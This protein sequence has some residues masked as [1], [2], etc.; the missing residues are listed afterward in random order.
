LP[1][2][3]IATVVA[4]V[5]AHNEEQ[6]IAAVISGARR[7]VPVVVVDDGSTD[8]T[9]RI[10]EY[11]SATV[12][13]Q[14]PNQGKGAALRTGF[15]W[16]LAQ[17]HAAVVT[18][19]ADGQHDPSEIPRFLDAWRSGSPDLVIGKR[20]FRTMP[21]VRRL[22]NVLGTAA[23]SWAVGQPIPD[24][25]SGFRLLSARLMEATLSSSEAG[26]EFEVEMIVTAMR[27]GWPIAWVPIRTIYAGEPSHI[28]PGRHLRRF[29]ET[30]W[31]ARRE[32]RRPIAPFPPDD[33]QEVTERR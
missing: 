31:R 3:E 11:T 10:A 22:A 2:H 1:R 19:D 7:F 26:F 32:V 23:L 9:A 8:R 5:P 30:A 25:Q 27:R 14:A 6:R 13:R 12:L 17:G 16:A 20:N 4:I 21:P 33:R 29:V 24:N 28:R 15:R 18:L